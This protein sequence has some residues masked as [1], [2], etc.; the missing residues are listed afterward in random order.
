MT[1]S[2]NKIL[3]LG[4]IFGLGLVCF[5]STAISEPEKPNAHRSLTKK[6]PKDVE[7][8]F[9]ETERAN[10]NSELLLYSDHGKVFGWITGDTD[11]S[12]DQVDIKVN[13]GNDKEHSVKVAPDNTFTFEHSHNGVVQV[14]AAVGDLKSVIFTQAIHRTSQFVYFVVDRTAYRPGQTLKFAGFLRTENADR[15]VV[16]VKDTEVQVNLLSGRKNTVAATLKLK[17]DEFGRITGEYKFSEGDGLDTYRLKIQ[18]FNG[19]A[20]VKLAEFRKA[21]VRLKIDSEIQD[22]KMTLKFQALDF[23]DK[24]VPGSNVRFDAKVIYVGNQISQSASLDATRFGIP[25]TIG[26]ASQIGFADASEDEKLLRD[27]GSIQMP[28]STGYVPPV[29]STINGDVEISEDGSGEYEVNLKRNWIKGGYSVVVEGVLTDYNGRE[30]RA[31]KTIPLGGKVTDCDLVLDIEKRFYKVGEPIDLKVSPT[32]DGEPVEITGTIVAMRLSPVAQPVNYGY[33]YYG[34]GYYGYNAYG[35]FGG[36]GLGYYAPRQINGSVDTDRTKRTMVNAT[37]VNGNGAEIVLDEPGAYKLVCIGKLPNGRE[38]K[39]EIGC[40]VNEPENL[41][42]LILNLDKEEFRSDENLTGWIHS[43]VRDAVAM[44]RLRDSMGVQKYKL[45]QLRDGM[46]RL[47][48]KIPEGIRYGTVV[49]VDFIQHER[50]LTASRFTR[51]LP[52]DRMVDVSISTDEVYQPGDTVTVNLDLNRKE[53]TD[54]VVSVFDKSLLGIAKDQAVDV[55]DYFL[56]DERVA[57]QVNDFA[58][59]RRLANIQ[60]KDLIEVAEKKLGFKVEKNTRRYRTLNAEL[61]ALHD[62]VYRYRASQYLYLEDIVQLLKASGHKV[63]TMHSAYGYNYSVHSSHMGRKGGGS[64]ETKWSQCGVYEILNRLGQGRNNLQF[65]MQGDTLQIGLTGYDPYGGGGFGGGGFGGGGLGGG[66]GMAGGRGAGFARG[67]ASR[68]IVSGNAM[69]SNVSGQSFI[70]HMPA[71]GMADTMIGGDSSV[72]VRRNFSDAA[73][74]NSKVR[75]D[76]NGKAEVT[77]KLPDS[78]TNWQVVVT[79]ITPE[80]HVGQSKSS[81]RTY[82]PVM[83]WPMLPRIFTEGDTV[84][85]YASVHNRTKEP[86]Q[87]EVSLEVENGEVVT[88]PRRTVTVPAESNVPVYWEFQP[89]EAGFT[90]LLMTAKSDAGS[91]ASLK[92]LPVTPMASEQWFTASGFLQNQG[93]LIVPD[94]IDLG[95]AEFEITLVPSLVNDTLDSLGYLVQYP[96]GC[97]EQTMSRFLPAIAVKGVLDKANIVDSELEEKLPKVAA[98]GI[99]RLLE[100]QRPDGGWGWHG[101]SQTHE[102]MTPYAMYGL[103]S[104]QDAGYNVPNS[105]ALSM[106][107]SRLQTF[108]GQMEQTKHPADRIYCMYVYSLRQ[109]IQTEWW[110]YIG[111]LVDGKMADGQKVKPNHRLAKFLEKNDGKIVLSDYALALALEMACKK[112][113]DELAKRLA[114]ELRKRVSGSKHSAFWTTANFSRWGNDRFEITAAVLKA[115]VAYDSDDTLIPRILN[116]FTDTKRGNKWNS[117]KDT[118]MILYAM[119]DYLNTQSFE[120]GKASNVKVSVGDWSEKVVLNPKKKTTIKIPAD[121]LEIGKNRLKFEGN[122]AGAMFRSVLTAYARGAEIQPVSSGVDV[123]REFFL[124][125]ESGE[126]VKELKSGDTIKK[127]SYIQSVVTA[128]HDANAAMSYVLVENPKPACCEILPDTDKRFKQASTTYALREDKTFGVAYHHERTPQTLV[129][130]CV[131][132]VE[133]GGQYMVPP[134]QV[135]LMYSTLERGSSGGFELRVK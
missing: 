29:A 130:R 116:F 126:I 25:S 109:E 71:A 66:Y 54:L 97:V 75:T 21:K 124:L 114:D 67:D 13:D 85:V 99:K 132:H 59:R 65:R 123:K 7:P 8:I 26:L 53:E 37:V 86:Q 131:L 62:A 56:A 93:E 113:K 110:D 104:A 3:F 128:K 118:A 44:V 108:V 127:G 51:I 101:G 28:I 49:E 100:L 106:G 1:F 48:L 47:D 41:P 12:G 17:S 36:G 115:L 18:G 61:Q 90:Q 80:L 46:A 22:R 52:V 20:L 95:D 111:I 96:H 9:E 10:T 70:S 82:K 14:E 87:M 77:F 74:W 68:A 134:A 89:G 119:C 23:L 76:S 73:F 6:A 2:S 107:L 69:F 32:L 135:E 98:A 16:P 94:G 39:N 31:S 133:L 78:L 92:R 45:V 15:K 84:R 19:Q 33:G 43:K 34:R 117:T 81:F 83:V 35:G 105:S 91:D 129:D 30:Q 4:M 79:A 88:R 63:L 40:V 102:M 27:F 121:R 122:L 125:D 24:G 120:P 42:S 58:V 103:L 64:R 55:K 57:W 60:L 112:D 38:L 50:L 11:F 5:F 72:S